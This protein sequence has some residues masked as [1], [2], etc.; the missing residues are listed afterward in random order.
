VVPLSILLGLVYAQ[1]RF[2][3]EKSFAS[4]HRF[5]MRNFRAYK[6]PSSLT[7]LA[8]S[9]SASIEDIALHAKQSQPHFNAFY[10][11]KS[12]TYQQV[13]KAVISSIRVD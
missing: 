9:I 3:S 13:K 6:T 1:R 11:A 8:L 12:Q 7:I 2:I 4:F 10:L 5:F